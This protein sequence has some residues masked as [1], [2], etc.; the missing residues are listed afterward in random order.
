MVEWFFSKAPCSSMSRREFK[1]FSSIFPGRGKI[2]MGLMFFSNLELPDFGIG[3]VMQTFQF[4]GK[5][6]VKRRR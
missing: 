5:D 6:P 3:V 2:D 1:I 4:L